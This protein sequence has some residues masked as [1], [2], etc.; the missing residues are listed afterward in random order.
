MTASAGAK[1]RDQDKGWTVEAR[2]EAVVA[3][4]GVRQSCFEKVGLETEARPESS[5]S[6]GE[7]AMALGSR[8]AG[9]KK[10]GVAVRIWRTK[11]GTGLGSGR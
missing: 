5:L 1:A 2:I 8:L 9:D 7:I 11:A 10:T 4:Q 6:G 3:D